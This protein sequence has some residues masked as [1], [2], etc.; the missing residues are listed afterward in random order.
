MF[1]AYLVSKNKPASSM[2]WMAEENPFFSYICG[3]KCD[4]AYPANVRFVNGKETTKKSIV[5]FQRAKP[6]IWPFRRDPF[7][8]YE[9]AGN[10]ELESDSYIPIYQVVGDYLQST[11]G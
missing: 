11:L 6:S 3:K 2:F 9:D 7:N 10:G 8:N 5:P 1:M 4:V